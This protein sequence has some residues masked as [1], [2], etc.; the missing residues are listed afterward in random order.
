MQVSYTLLFWPMGVLESLN[1]CILEISKS[2]L[3]QSYSS[4]NLRSLMFLSKLYCVSKVYVLIYVFYYLALNFQM[5]SY[6]AHYFSF[7]GI[8]FKFHC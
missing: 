1:M 8:H 7:A 6:W 3:G 4:A 5:F 2:R